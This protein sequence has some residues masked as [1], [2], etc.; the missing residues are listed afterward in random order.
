MV[1]NQII[2]GIGQGLKQL[3][4][5]T[6]E[7]LV[8]ETG[9]ILEPIITA[10]ELL[11]DI[12]PMSD[13]ELAQKKQQ[14]EIKK[15]QEINKLKSEIGQGRKVEDEMTQL[16]RQ[17]E[18]QQEKKEEYYERE[19]QQR[20]RE[21]QRQEEEYNNSLMAES[22]NPAKQKKSRGSALAHKKKSQPDQSQMSQT[23]EFN[24]GGKID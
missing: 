4:T 10:K 8:E 13:Q 6:A 16:R 17:E 20:E 12:T 9:K 7:K 24:K 21:R 5:E 23:Q 22:S 1:N 15:Q 2:K 19:K 3:G 18:E 14:E 11:G